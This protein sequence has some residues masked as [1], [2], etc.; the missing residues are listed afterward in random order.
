M[1]S[2][3]SDELGLKKA[4]LLGDID[5][6]VNPLDTAFLNINAGQRRSIDG[7]A[8]PS[9]VV[10]LSSQEFSRE[11]LMAERRRLAAEREFLLRR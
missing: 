2:I 5:W 11:A 4:G 6:S 1:H 7:K 3:G 10:G 9:N 8:F